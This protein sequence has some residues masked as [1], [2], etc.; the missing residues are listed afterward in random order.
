LLSSANRLGHQFPA[1]GFRVKEP[2]EGL[3]ESLHPSRGDV[4]VIDAG[5]GER[6]DSAFGFVD[7]VGDGGK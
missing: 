2:A 6:L 4:V 3:G 1:L 7:T 5:L